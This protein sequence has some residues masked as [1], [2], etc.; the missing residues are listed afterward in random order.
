MFLC[1]FTPF[2][3]RGDVDWRQVKELHDSFKY[4]SSGLSGPAAMV[5]AIVVAYFTAGAGAGL[6]GATGTVTAAASN[7]VASAMISNAA[8][9]TINN[10]GNLGAALKEVTSSDNLKSYAVTGITAGLTAGVYDKWTGTQT[11]ASN[12]ATASNNSGILANSGKVAGSALSEWSG[13]GQFAANQALQN[14]TSAVL[15]KALGQ[16]G[17][18]G[19]ALTSTLAN[20]FAAAGF[21]WVGDISV[22]R[23]ENGSL[24]KIGLHA[25]M[26]GL[27]AEAAGGDFK[28]GALVAG[29][30]E[31]LID[32]L[33]NQYDNMSYERRTGLL[34]MNS[35]V[36]GVLVA[37]VAG[38]DEKDMQTGAWVAGNAT[39]YNRQLH[40]DEIE[41]ASDRERVQRYADEHGLSEEAARQELLRT[42]AALVDRGWNE[43]LTA[44]DGKTERAAVFLENELAGH[45]IK[46][47]Q[48]TPLEYNNERLGLK[49]L[50]SDKQ[51]LQALLV[52]VA[53]VDP[54]DYKTNPQYYQ[55]V[56]NAKGLGSQEG[57]GNAVENLASAPSKTALWLM[58]AANCPDCALA[59][60]Q[61][62]WDAVASMP[63]ELK[64]KGYLD[65]LHIMQGKGF[66]V[67]KG[68]AASSTELGVGVGLAVTPVL[69][70]GGAKATGKDYVDILSP[71]AKKHILYGDK[72][73]SGGHMWPGQS[74]KTV[75]PQS[76]SADKI[77]HEV[78]DIATSPNTKWYAQTGTG[79]IYT[80]NGDPAKWVAYEVRDGVR[81]RVVYQPAAGKVITAFPDNAPIPPYKL[82]K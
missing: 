22:G 82:I 2:E 69:G 3:K 66:E 57:F 45:S 13:V 36:L 9:S 63:E 6:I 50:F 53:L 52:E 37:S 15:N 43:A 26:G 54:L 76:W 70:R 46:M 27:A 23:F 25:I 38:G 61:Q 47:F 64:Y 65:N 1:G 81:M 35:Q 49:E 20:T 42:A 14:S 40:P 16:D 72:P 33:A 28:S 73:G 51:A 55:E 74:G 78:G 68:N 12:T 5:I 77:V 62:A 30:N 58:G 79:G 4:S 11:G 71:E 29:A 18:L 44:A 19:D 31:A 60:I 75:F 48:T 41:F 24:S 34:T 56:L 10:K 80:S 17:S 59:D 8:I 39:S 67:I 21:N 32:T 7:A